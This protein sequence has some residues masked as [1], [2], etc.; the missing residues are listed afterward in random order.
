MN[1]KIIALMLFTLVAVG[2]SSANGDI[3]GSLTAS[4]TAQDL[5]IGEKINYTLTLNTNNASI[6]TLQLKLINNIEVRIRDRTPAPGTW[7]EWQNGSGLLSF[8]FTNSGIDGQLLDME[9]QA[10]DGATI[11]TPYSVSIFYGIEPPF[12]ITAFLKAGGNITPELSTLA[13]MGVGL[14]GLIG[15]SRL[16]KK[17]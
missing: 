4:P 15:M 17:K 8:D 2:L 6:N 11:N 12:D 1:K 13:L 9:V 14:L 16:Q 10:I 7:S 5:P 3:L